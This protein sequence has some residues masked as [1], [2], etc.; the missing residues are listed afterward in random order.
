MSFEEHVALFAS[1]RL[2]ITVHSAGENNALF[3]P[4]RSTV[5]EVYGQN[6]WCPI[7]HRALTA[8][9][10]HVF[11]IYSKA[12]S[13]TQDYAYSYGR[14]EAIYPAMLAKFRRCERLG[15]VQ[16]SKG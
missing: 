9:G 1:H 6:M 11:P 7:Y 2:L 13:P 15:N 5:I 14:D 8:S 12:N 3:L 10:H 16:A 4:P